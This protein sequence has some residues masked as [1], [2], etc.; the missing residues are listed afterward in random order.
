MALSAHDHV[1]VVG[2]GLAGWRVCEELRRHGFEGQLT[3]VGDEVHVPYD[4][5]PLSKKVMAGKWSVEHTTLA[6]PERL[7]HAKVHLRLGV[8]ATHLDAEKPAV[9]LSDGSVVTGT[10]VVIATGA[11]ARRLAWYEPDLYE[12]RNLDD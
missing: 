4:R 12:L 1:V 7:E 10:H 11:R 3:L 2:A 5:P 6:T 9:T 8:K